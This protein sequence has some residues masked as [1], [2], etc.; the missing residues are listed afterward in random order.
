MEGE[1]ILLSM[2]PDLSQRRLE[3]AYWH[4]NVPGLLGR[5][6]KNRLEERTFPDGKKTRYVD[7]IPLGPGSLASELEEAHR[8]KRQVVAS[9]LERLSNY[10]RNSPDPVNW[11]AEYDDTA[12]PDTIESQKTLEQAFRAI[13]SR[14]S[15]MLQEFPETTFIRVHM[16]D[17]PDEDLVYTML[18]NKGHFNVDR[19]FQED[20][21]ARE[22]SSLAPQ[23][24]T[25]HFVRGFVGSYPN[26]YMHFRI[27][28]A[29]E[30]IADLQAFLL[31]PSKGLSLKQVWKISQ[32]HNAKRDSLREIS[33]KWAV[34]RYQPDFWDYHQWFNDKFRKMDPVQAGL[35]D[36][37]RYG[38]Y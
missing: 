4:R 19:L 3:Y 18:R 23:E 31:Q 30:A 6:V 13:S 24:D 25:L 11:N 28:Q 38:N 14:K 37:T 17:N 20:E 1:E 36:L 27:D 33:R 7:L 32:D 9:L 8:A 15:I 10:F 29:S 21:D 34:S 26:L 22:L 2:M 35:F 16:N 12:A 5:Q